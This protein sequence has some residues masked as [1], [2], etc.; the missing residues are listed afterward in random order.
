LETESTLSRWS[1]L[2]TCHNSSP[3]HGKRVHRSQ[4]Q[5]RTKSIWIVK[6]RIAKHPINYQSLN[7]IQFCWGLLSESQ[8]QYNFLFYVF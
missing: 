7:K 3:M 6:I 2:R 4:K 1:S 5:R 8:T